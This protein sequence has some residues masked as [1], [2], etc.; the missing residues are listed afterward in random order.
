M[1]IQS[2]GFTH[3]SDGTLFPLLLRLEQ[4]GYFDTE[5]VAVSNGPKRKYY[6][7]N[8]NGKEELSRFIEAWKSLEDNVNRT[9][10]RGK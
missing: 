2:L 4:E 1:Q 9:L 10:K 3:V 7:L 6:T 8:S 5:L